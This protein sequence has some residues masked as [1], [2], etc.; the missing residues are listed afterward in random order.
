MG[1]PEFSGGPFLFQE[2]EKLTTK[3]PRRQAGGGMN[4]KLVIFLGVFAAWWLKIYLF[5][6]R[7]GSLGHK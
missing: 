2:N 5:D 1:P 6:F 4:S 3:T 7:K